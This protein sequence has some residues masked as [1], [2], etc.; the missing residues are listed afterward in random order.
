MTYVAWRVP[1]K[2]TRLKTM[3]RLFLIS[4]VIL[5]GSPAV[6]THIARDDVHGRFCEQ[7][8]G[9]FRHQTF[10]PCISPEVVAPHWNGGDKTRDD[11]QANMILG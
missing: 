10:G 3:A 2:R 8:A 5:A 4:V 9:A 11:W 1:T 6:A 7:R